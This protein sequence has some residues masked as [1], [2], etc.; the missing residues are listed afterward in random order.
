MRW[1]KAVSVVLLLLLG[2]I[3]RAETLEAQVNLAI[4]RGVKVVRGQLGGDGA[5]TTKYHRDYPEG[6]TALALYTLVKSGVSAD[7]PQVRKSLAWLLPRPPGSTYGA[8]VF[9]LALDACKDRAL[10]PQILATA[11]WLEEKL[12]PQSRRWGYPGGH[13]DLS[14][15]QYAALGLWA[16][17]RHGYKARP[18]TWAALL[19]GV[20]EL[21][22]PDDGFA[23]RTDSRT[24]GSMT[25]A[26]LTVLEL[27]LERAPSG[28]LPARFADVRQKAKSALEKGWAYL[29]RRFTV[30]GNPLGLHTHQEDWLHYYLYGVERLCAITSRERIGAHDWYAEGARQLVATQQAD[31][32]WGESC[33][34]CFALLFLRRATFTTLDR[35]LPRLTGEGVPRRD[36]FTPPRADVPFIRRW[37]MLGP[38]EDPQ[39]ELVEKS[40]FEESRACPHPL[41]YS[42]A[43]R[44]NPS[45]SLHDRVDLGG[46]AT[47]NVKTLT[48]AFV[49]IHA[50][51]ESEAVLWFGHD[52]G[53]RVWFDGRLVHDRHFEEAYGPDRFSVPVVLTP[54]AHRLLV[55]VQ[56]SG[57]LHT[58]WMRI[59]RTDGS[60]VPGMTTSLDEMDLET[61]AETAANPT[62]VPPEMLLLAL[63]RETRARL[64]F[65]DSGQIER[66][67]FD[68]EYG[69]YPLWDADPGKRPSHV[70]NPGA[71]GVIAIHP[72]GPD[73][74][75]NLYWK[76]RVPE[77]ARLRLRVSATTTSSPGKADVALRLGVFDGAMTWIVTE[78]VGPDAKADAANWRWVEA[79]LAAWAGREVVLVI[80]A[81][82]GGPTNWHWE[83]LWIDEMEVRSGG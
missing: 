70:P 58:L 61:E 23:Y 78:A 21:R 5:G 29:E 36:T 38:L 83:G 53:A 1:S 52:N 35:D 46:E 26:G 31:G 55:K 10:D 27:A 6:D 16:A 24:T 20:A 79:P 28:D 14:N 40:F 72:A 63:P 4:D 11:K 3:A 69:P 32:S 34:T 62:G 39:D 75:S 44:W 76:V 60:R 37:L 68:G 45:R 22:M 17:E 30:Q 56:N 51:D 2:R 65:D 25:V 7:D 18:D 73:R 15:T 64:S 81:G 80:Q 67:A 8:A 41:S 57:G 66:L 54:G 19:A 42:N 47:P 49:W 33:N 77:K 48:C 82:N 74:P 9:I 59:A 13:T 43:W 12:H 71:T 50:T